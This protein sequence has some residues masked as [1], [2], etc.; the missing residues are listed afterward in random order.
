MGRKRQEG[1]RLWLKAKSVEDR[2][3]QEREKTHRRAARSEAAPHRD[4]P[5]YDDFPQPSAMQANGLRQRPRRLQ[6]DPRS[7]DEELAASASGFN[8]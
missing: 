2:A 5:E 7:E 1:R 8:Q 6:E 4:A 3:K